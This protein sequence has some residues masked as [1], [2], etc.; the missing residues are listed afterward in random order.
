M[1]QKIT[2]R[3]GIP[4]DIEVLGT[5]CAKCKKLEENVRNAVAELGIEATVTKV[6]DIAKIM[7]NGVMST[8]G[9]VIDGVVKSEG[10]IPSQQEI[11]GWLQGK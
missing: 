3:G 11:K 6:E 1:R 2:N 5:G 9:V 8:P 10:R 4:M 7:E